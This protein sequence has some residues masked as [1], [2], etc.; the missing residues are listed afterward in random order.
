M[1]TDMHTPSLKVTALIF[2]SGKTLAF[3]N[4]PG[5][6]VRLPLA[7]PLPNLLQSPS[8]CP[9]VQSYSPL[10]TLILTKLIYEH[11][12]AY[13]CPFLPP[14]HSERFWWINF[15]KTLL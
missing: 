2:P 7:Y 12:H 4:C 15:S 8:V 14:N 11:N 10:S 13:S 5:Q 9:S 3:T 1:Y 6:R